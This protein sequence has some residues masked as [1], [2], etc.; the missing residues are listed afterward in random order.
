MLPCH[1]SSPCPLYSKPMAKAATPTVADYLARQP[2]GARKTL[3]KV[4]AAIR[5]ALPGAEETISYQIPSYKL[6]DAYVVYFAGWKQ[7]YAVYPVSATVRAAL[8]DALAPYAMSKGTVRFPYSE[9]V[10][11]RLIERLAVLLAKEARA[12]RKARRR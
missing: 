9:P 6:D 5:K 11:V 4:R 10:P 2:D 3:R 12:R 1:G 8:A 7:H